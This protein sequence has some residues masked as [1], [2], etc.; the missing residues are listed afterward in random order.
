MNESQEEKEML[1]KVALQFRTA[2]EQIV[3][4][5]NV[6]NGINSI[7]ENFP[8]TA[9]GNTSELLAFYFLREKGI[10][11]LVNT[12]GFYKEGGERK[13]SHEWIE[14]Q[15][16]YIIDITSDQFEGREGK[17]VVVTDKTD[18]WYKKF[19][20]NVTISFNGNFSKSC[21]SDLLAFYKMIVD[22]INSYS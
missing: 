11:V 12:N 2:I 6:P 1:Y 14:Y 21:E 16:K 19:K 10:K 18:A 20:G 22:K 7:F 9:C 8:R 3:E 15:D 5:K 13:Y 4:E 17:A